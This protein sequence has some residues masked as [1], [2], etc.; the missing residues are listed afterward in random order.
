MVFV[1][2][3]TRH[4]PQP[5]TRTF[6][7][8]AVRQRFGNISRRAWSTRC[9]SRCPLAYSVPENPCSPVSIFPALDTAQSSARRA[10]RP[11]TTSSR[12]VSSNQAEAEKSLDP[13]P[14]N[15]HLVRMNKRDFL[16]TAGGGGLSLLLGEKLWAKYTELPIERLAEEETFWRAIRGKYRLKTDYINL[17][18]GY[19][20]M[21]AS[22]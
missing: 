2:P 11:C 16:R 4:G 6:D 18:N 17:E 1:P 7:C 5:E 12:V 14:G 9:T 3:W 10:R 8:S 22:P 15:R 19:Y 21:Q 20:S 13:L